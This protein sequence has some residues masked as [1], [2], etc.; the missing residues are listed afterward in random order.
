[1]VVAVITTSSS[2]WL[3]AHA[4]HT[5]CGTKGRD[6]CARLPAP[7]QIPQAGTAPDGGMSDVT[8]HMRSSARGG[9]QL[10]ARLQQQVIHHS[11]CA[12]ALAVVYRSPEPIRAC[13]SL[14]TGPAFG[15]P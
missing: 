11:L 4:Q 13:V 8:P 1:M 10:S 2:A 15:P 12:C 3:D 14:L 5:I 7:L 6:P 9:L